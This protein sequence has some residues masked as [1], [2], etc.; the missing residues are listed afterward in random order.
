MRLVVGKTLIGLNSIRNALPYT[1][2][3]DVGARVR[4]NADVEWNTFSS[5]HYWQQNYYEL[6]PEDEEI[7]RRV[8]Q[9]FTAAFRGR[10]CTGRGIDVGSGTNLYPALLMLPWTEQ[11]LLTD[12]AVS[13][14]H[15]LRS[16]LADDGDGWTWQ[17]FWDELQEAERYN[18]IDNPRKHLQVACQ[19]EPGFAGVEEGSVFGL[20]E[21]RWDLGTMFFVA[22]SITQDAGEFDAA[23]AC[24]VRALKPGAPF[25]AAFM[26]GSCGYRVAGTKF[27]ALPIDTDDVRRR[28]SEL[29]V[30]DLSVELLLTEHR[31]RDGY[32]GMIVATGVVRDS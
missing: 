6:L 11:I 4:R 24:F 28:F 17:P 31:V 3:V 22:E 12:Y 7:I 23:L 26:A 2:M 14:V 30:G 19:D 10:P 15:W 29:G 8:S 16:Q 27:P 21:A 1:L 25:A 13:N 20:P 9:F 18:E 32:E 5:Q